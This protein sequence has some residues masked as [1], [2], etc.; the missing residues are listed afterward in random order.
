[1][2]KMLDEFRRQWV[3]WITLFFAGGMK[4]LVNQLEWAFARS[5]VVCDTPAQP[6]VFTGSEHC[7]DYWRVIGEGYGITSMGQAQENFWMLCSI[8]V[9]AVVTQVFGR[10]YALLLGLSGTAASVSLFLV[11]I[12]RPQHG[13]ALYAVGQGLQGL[14]PLEYLAGM[15]VFDM[16]R[17]AGATL[18]VFEL[19]SVMDTWRKILWEVGM[20]NAVQWFQLTN[21][22]YVWL[23][24]MAVNV[25]FLALVMVAFP[26]TGPKAEHGGGSAVQ[27]V[28]KEV[29]SYRDVFT[30]WK[31]RRYLTSKLVEI[32]WGPHISH[33]LSVAFMAYHGWTQQQIVFCMFWLNPWGL[34]CLS[35]REKLIG[36]FGNH[37]TY[38]FC[39]SWVMSMMIIL[40]IA[41]PVS[42]GIPV[43]CLFLHATLSGFVP[44]RDFVASRFCHADQMARFAN[45]QWILGYFFGIFVSPMYGSI[46]DASA[47]TYLGKA[48]PSLVM[49]CLAI[50]TLIANVRMYKL[51][52]HDGWGVTTKQLDEGAEKVPRLWQAV[53]KGG[54][55]IPVTEEVWK[56]AGLEK[57]WGKAWADTGFAEWQGLWNPEQLGGFLGYISPDGK[58]SAE[59]LRNLGAAI[60]SAEAWAGEAKGASSASAEGKKDS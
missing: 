16:S 53:T 51:T 47:T 20:G 56:A 12:A 55:Q 40:L 49:L 3:V 18:V 11:A 29:L 59:M 26:E 28:I 42:A 4:T 1:M 5:L 31:A 25:A 36:R 54:T 27:K 30:D 44:L 58:S 32:A 33:V 43:V 14:C 7:G 9:A 46:F 37:N 10:R 50:V 6:G 60:E 17:A 38:I 41:L 24:V 57:A 52:E 8:C 45:V 35:L 19:G 34:I 2:G 21:Y 22:F 15:V 23:G 39:L 48:K 13:R